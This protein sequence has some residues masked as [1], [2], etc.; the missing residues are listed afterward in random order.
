MLLDKRG[1]MVE[2]LMCCIMVLKYYKGARKR[3]QSVKHFCRYENLRSPP[4]IQCKKVGV[5][6][7][8]CNPRDGELKRGGFWGPDSPA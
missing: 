2:A 3:T 1:H 8:I 4:R 5:A 7:C 6:E